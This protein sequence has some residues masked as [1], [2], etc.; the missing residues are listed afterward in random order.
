[1]QIKRDLADA[2]ARKEALEREKL[3]YARELKR[4][5]DERGMPLRALPP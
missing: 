4:V 2:I 1:M 5:N 3:V